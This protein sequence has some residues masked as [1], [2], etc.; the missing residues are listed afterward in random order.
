MPI[1]RADW[2]TND[3]AIT[4]ARA[5]LSRA[6][7]SEMSI[8][9]PNPHCGASIASADCTS[10]RGSPER[11]PSGKGR[12]RRQS[13]QQLAVDEQAPHLLERHVPDQLLDVDAAVAQRAT[14][15]VGLGDL[16]R[17]G[18]DALEARLDFGSDA[19]GEFSWIGDVLVL[20]GGGS[21][22]PVWRRRCPDSVAG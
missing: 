11:T 22:R 8:S 17:E 1:P 4:D 12:G 5:R 18:D 19:H 10:T 3:S 15:A 2:A 16:G 9:C 13:G 20:P 7:S 21:D 6:S 14:G